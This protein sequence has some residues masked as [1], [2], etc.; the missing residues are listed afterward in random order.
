MPNCGLV[1]LLWVGK[2]Q[3]GGKMLFDR[4]FNDNQTTALG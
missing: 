1:V 3:K 2:Q 4:M